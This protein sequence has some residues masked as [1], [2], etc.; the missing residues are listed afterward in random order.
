M[1]PGVSSPGA[2]ADAPRSP[3]DARL[4][5]LWRRAVPFAVAAVL[6]G[7]TVHR[8]DLRAFVREV[9]AVNVPAFVG[10]AIAFVLCLLTADAFAT[11]VVYGRTVAK[12]RFVDFWI[13]RG[14]SYLPSLLNHHVGQVFITYYLAR[15]HGV[16]LAR[17]AGGT[18]L[19]YVS[20]AGCLLGTGCLA[21]VAAGQPLLQPALLF[22]AGLAYLAV[23]ALRPAPLARVKLLAPLF[24][25]GLG[26][27]TV[28]VLARIPHMMVLFAGTWVPFLFFGVKIPFTRALVYVPIVMVGVT[29]P[30]TP[31]GLGTRDLLAARFFSAFAPGATE[32]LQRASIAAATTSF[33]IGFTLVEAAL[34]LLLLRK[35]LP[36]LEKRALPRGE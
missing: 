16:S 6:I 20:W 19:A 1:T 2:P 18:L 14:A 12:I 22:A 3:T 33:V 17:M 27:H 8:L 36:S 32:A 15:I 7:Y 13:L 31:Q 4:P 21:L 9:A 11:T 10:F 25:A 34:G 28:A 35:A 26:G 23:I 30:L 5:P 29:L 24:E